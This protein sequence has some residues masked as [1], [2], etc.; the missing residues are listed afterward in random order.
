MKKTRR[1]RRSASTCTE[2]GQFK[3]MNFMSRERVLKILKN[4]GVGVS[5]VG[6]LISFV[7]NSAD[8]GIFRDGVYLGAPLT[9]N[10]FSIGFASPEEILQRFG[11][12]MIFEREERLMLVPIQTDICDVLFGAML[13]HELVHASDVLRGGFP[14]YPSKTEMMRGEVRAYQLE[15]QILD[16]RTGGRLRKTVE[17]IL[18]K[19]AYRN[20]QSF[21]LRDRPLEEKRAFVE[22]FPQTG[23]LEDLKLRVFLLPVA[24][25]LIS[26]E[27]EGRDPLSGITALL[28]DQQSRSE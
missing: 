15:I 12:P 10:C 11:A 3:R 14:V 19:E 24:M 13:F 21:L 28:D 4:T 6:Q 20:E 18:S 17:G 27:N 26:A 1:G 8:F 9:P 22:L 25:N 2:A 16:R 23:Y 5:T 7:E